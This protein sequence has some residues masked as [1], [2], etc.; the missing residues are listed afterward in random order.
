MDNEEIRQ[1]AQ[2]LMSERKGTQE[3]VWIDIERYI[4]P[5]RGDFSNENVTEN[6]INVARQYVYDGASA[7]KR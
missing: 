6:S 7:A 5:Y 1:R 3:Q 2:R 4:C